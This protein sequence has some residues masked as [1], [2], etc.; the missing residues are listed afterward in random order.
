MGKLAATLNLRPDDRTR[1]TAG[2]YTG[3]GGKVL[4]VDERLQIVT[5]QLHVFGKQAVIKLRPSELEAV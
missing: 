4:T 3:W 5:V 1:V 2:A